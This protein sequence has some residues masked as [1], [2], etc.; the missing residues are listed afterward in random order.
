MKTGVG[1]AG[2]CWPVVAVAPNAMP[3]L[4]DAPDDAP[5]PQLVLEAGPV[6]AAAPRGSCAE[7]GYLRRCRRLPP[8]G[9]LLLPD[10]PPQ[11]LLLLQLMGTTCGADTHTAPG[12]GVLLVVAV[13]DVVIGRPLLAAEAAVCAVCVACAASSAAIPSKVLKVRGG[14]GQAG[15]AG[16]CKH[17]HNS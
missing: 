7:G 3:R 9:V 14:R 10:D 4:D 17:P 16:A 12:R 13:Y 8:Q 6:R 5:A 15:T 2:C 1:A 11:V